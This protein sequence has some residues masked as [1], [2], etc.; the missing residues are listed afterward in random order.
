MSF[1]RGNEVV[2][3]SIVGGPQTERGI[4]GAVGIVDLPSGKERIFLGDVPINRARPKFSGDVC[5]PTRLWMPRSGFPGKGA[6][7]S[8]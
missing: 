6:F 5:A 3:G 7:G 2:V 8:G 1:A 4:V